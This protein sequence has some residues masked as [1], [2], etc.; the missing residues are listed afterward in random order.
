MTAN[1]AE[2]SDSTIKMPVLFVGHGSPMNAI[3][4]TEFSLA[5]AEAGQSLPRPKAVLCISAH[6]E[7]VG[8]HVTAAE[9]PKTIYD[10][11]GFPQALYEV[12]YPAPGSP[13]LAGLV[14]RT[15]RTTPVRLDPG[16]G[17]DHGAWAVLCRMFP[18]AD[19]PV[20]Q[21]SL[22]RG[23]GPAFHYGLAQEL[24]SLRDKGVLILGSGN[25]VHNLGRM[26]WEDM[27]FDWAVEFDQ[28]MRQLIAAGDHDAIIHYENLGQAAHLSVPTREHFL[29]LLYVLAL[30]DK[31]EE[32]VFFAEKVTL[33]SMS[34]RSVRMG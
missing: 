34:M 30:Q 4:D 17:L 19:V 12:S 31:G 3:E 20:V 16:R 27:A 5:W 8:T 23:K 32:L 6:W 18:E 22:D 21:L 10:F 14:Q 7:T 26:A 25:I 11:L 13:A 1:L 2:F 9:R 33:G 29:P 24:R 15:L 28:K